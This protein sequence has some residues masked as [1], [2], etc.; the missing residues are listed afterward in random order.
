MLKKTEFLNAMSMAMLVLDSRDKAY[1]QCRLVE[2]GRFS[3]EE[4]E[5][6]LIHGGVSV[7]LGVLF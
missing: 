7:C 5:K 3:A 1:W 4:L 6:N 2:E